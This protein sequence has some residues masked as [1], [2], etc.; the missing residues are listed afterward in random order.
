M[1]YALWFNS[2]FSAWLVL[3]SGLCLL[4]GCG[5]RVATVTGHVKLDNQPLKGARLE[6]APE[7]GRPSSATTDE[8]GY[9]ELKYLPKKNGAEIG[10]HKVVIYLPEKMDDDGKKIPPAVVI[11]EKYNTKSE[12]IREV[13]AGSNEIDF[14]LKSK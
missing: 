8:S 9:Y 6:F 4:A 12:L 2:R 11:P 13:N 3:A 10:K 1:H 7:E 14:D 5:D